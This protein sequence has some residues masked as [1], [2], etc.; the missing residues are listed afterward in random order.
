MI[1]TNSLLVYE[2]SSNLIYDFLINYFEINVEC[3]NSVPFENFSPLDYDNTI[4]YFFISLDSIESLFTI[5]KEID[6][7]FNA[8]VLIIPKETNFLLNSLITVDTTILLK[9]AT[10]YGITLSCLEVYENNSEDFEHFFKNYNEVEKFENNSIYNLGKK[11]FFSKEYIKK[12]DNRWNIFNHCLRLTARELQYDFKIKFKKAESIDNIAISSLM[13]I[14]NYKLQHYVPDITYDILQYFS[15]K[16]YNKELFLNH[17]FDKIYVLYLPRRKDLTVMELKKLGIWNY[18]LF[19]GFDASKSNVC[20]KEYEKYQKFYPSEDE[21]RILGKKDRRGIGSVGSWAILKSMHNML[22]NAKRNGYQRIL[23]LQDDTIFHNDFF[24]EFKSKI[25]VINDEKWKLLYLGASQHEWRSVNILNDY[26][27]PTGTTDG[28]FAIGIHNS[29]F[30][31]IITEISKFNLPFDSGALWKAQSKHSE[32]CYVIYNNIIIADLH[33]S[34]LRS[35]R[36]MNS[37]SELFHWKLDNYT[38]K[39]Q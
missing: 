22:V 35:S 34:D 39:N 23:V 13:D 14:P 26:Y 7:V 6:I 37:F 2:E 32:Q 1:Q 38:L 21:I 25:N 30:D 4:I 3:C 29:L 36:D 11:E 31:E 28:A 15:L 18:S 33:S 8:Y 10:Y 19:E 27:H 17:Y 9:R 16:C 24:E 20:S 12:I 5:L